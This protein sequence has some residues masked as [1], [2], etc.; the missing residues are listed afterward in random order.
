MGLVKRT[1]VDGETVI[2]A[3]NLND[4]QDA[5]IQNEEDITTKGTYSK[6][7]G[8]I[9]KTDLASAVQTSLEKADT[10]L[11][12]SDID[13]TLTVAGKAADAKKTGDEISDVR[14]SLNQLKSDV[15]IIEDTNTAQHTIYKNQ[16]VIWKGSLYTASQNISSGTTL[17]NSNLSLVNNGGLNSLADWLSGRFGRSGILITDFNSAADFTNNYVEPNSVSFIPFATAALHQPTTAS[18]GVCLVYFGGSSSNFLNL[19]MNAAGKMYTRSY[20]AG[21]FTSW[22]EH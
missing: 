19:Y 11:Q 8:G 20:G 22:T 2:T 16:Y 14:T 15:G 7:T 18:W 1:Y 21:A 4:I 10:A 12:S 13:N 6:P 5:I 17:S 9:P 3:D